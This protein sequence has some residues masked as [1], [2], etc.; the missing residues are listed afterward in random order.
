MGDFESTESSQEKYKFVDE[1][2]E[3]HRTSNGFAP[4][5]LIKTRFLRL[6]ASELKTLL[7]E[8][9]IQA[10]EVLSSEEYKNLQAKFE[11][12]NLLFE[13]LQLIKTKLETN[14]YHNIDLIVEDFKK[15][16]QT[17]DNYQTVLAFCKLLQPPFRKKQISPEIKIE[18][19][20]EK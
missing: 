4:V 20:K 10:G 1:L 12:G 19:L 6:K 16:I 3:L 18:R 9:D 15:Q 8:T 13:K 5:N 2:F 7:Q 17:T 14:D 11:S